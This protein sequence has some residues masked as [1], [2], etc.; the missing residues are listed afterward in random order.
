MSTP[1][2]P[3]RVPK[4]APAAKHERRNAMPRDSDLLKI[5]TLWANPNVS[6]LGPG[7]E[8]ILANARKAPAYPWKHVGNTTG[9][10]LNE[11]IKKSPRA[12]SGGTKRKRH[13]RRDR[14]TR[15]R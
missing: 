13:S 1:K 6:S 11:M 7:I 10:T 3:P 15:R 14:H 9:L 8:N 2:R 4:E 12:Q 5:K